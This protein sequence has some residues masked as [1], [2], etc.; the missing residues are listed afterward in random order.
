MRDPVVVTLPFNFG[1]KPQVDTRT[2]CDRIAD[3]LSESHREDTSHEFRLGLIQG[4]LAIALPQLRALE[5]KSAPKARKTA[6]RGSRR[7]A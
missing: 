4:A 7:H 6:K 1:Q 3:T 5:A 2:L